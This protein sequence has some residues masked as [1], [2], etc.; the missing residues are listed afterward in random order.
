MELNTVAIFSFSS[1]ILSGFVCIFLVVRSRFKNLEW[2]LLTGLLLTATIELLD[3]FIVLTPGHLLA[4]KPPVFVCEAFLPLCWVFYATGVKPGPRLF[5]KR[6]ANVVFWSGAFLLILLSSLANAGHMFALIGIGRETLLLLGPPGFFFYLMLSIYLVTALVLLE[7]SFSSL[8]RRDRWNLKFEVLGIG[9]IITMQAVYYSQ[10]LIY[11]TLDM[12]LVSARSTAIVL[13]LLLFLYSR[14][15]RKAG[16]RLRLSHAAGFR[17]IVLLIVSL[18]LIFIALAG[19]G[20][21]Y[22]GASSN[23]AIMY[24]LIVASALVLM[25]LVLSE[26]LRRKARVFLY[27]HFYEQKYDHRVLWMEMTDRLARSQTD[28]SLYVAVLDV[29]C[30]TFAVRGGALYLY[31]NTRDE[32]A[33][34]A[35]YEGLEGPEKISSDGSLVEFLV[36]KKWVFN[37]LENADHISADERQQLEEHQIQFVI[38]LF[39][40]SELGGVIA[41]GRQINSGE[42]IIY[43]DYD[44][45]KIYSRQVAATLYSRQLSRQLALNREMAAVGKVSAFVMHDLKNLVSNLTLMVDNA[46]DLIQDRR[47]QQDMLKTLTNS[48]NRMNELIGRLKNVVTSKA[49][50]RETLDLKELINE[51]IDGLDRHR[52][53]VSGRDVDVHLDRAEF[54]KVI[55]NLVLNGIEASNDHS[56]VELEIESEDEIVLICRDKGSGIPVEYIDNHLFRP[57]ETTKEKGLGVGLYQARQIVESHG[58]RIEVTSH[59]GEGTEFRVY[60]PKREVNEVSNRE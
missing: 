6:L 40:N 9:A 35:S 21:R 59:L 31:R 58:G 45:M 48:V 14:L 15:K 27:K 60:I 1:V 39:F 20:F 46:H 53:N 52:I 5:K 44:L 10:G 51:S 11:K 19:E 42:P 57:F 8:S 18:Y 26:S 12:S 50:Q 23:R 56:A 49:L 22:M 41:L 29:Y 54:G 30:R 47:F 43:E 32:L 13:G 34:I 55:T 3:I 4:L 17:S 24:C 28:E 25:T 7:R 36:S 2:P 37:L 33:E 38:P 16:A